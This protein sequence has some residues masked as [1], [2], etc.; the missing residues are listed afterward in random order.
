MTLTDFGNPGWARLWCYC[1]SRFKKIF[2]FPI[3]QIWQYLMK[4]ISETLS[5]PNLISTLL[6]LT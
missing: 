4:V 5:V 2:G 3:F 1:S 6:L